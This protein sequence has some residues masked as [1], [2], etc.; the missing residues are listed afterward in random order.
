LPASTKNI[1]AALAAEIVDVAYQKVT[2]ARDEL[3]EAQPRG[4]Q[5][6]REGVC[7]IVDAS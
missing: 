4:W 1:K 3:R 6:V 5:V 7:A 2:A